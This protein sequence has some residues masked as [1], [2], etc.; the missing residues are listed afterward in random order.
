MLMAVSSLGLAACGQPAVEKVLGMM[1][2]ELSMVMGQ[3]G[4]PT[5]LAIG[6][7]HIGVRN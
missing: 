4:A 3:M 7:K 6:P 1:K 5:I 2:A